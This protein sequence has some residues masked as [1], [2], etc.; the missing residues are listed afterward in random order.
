MDYGLSKERIVMKAKLRELLPEKTLQIQNALDSEV[1]SLY[2]MDKMWNKGFGDWE[3]ECKYRSGEK[4][5]CT[6]YAPKDVVAIGKILLITGDMAA[7]NSVF[8][9]QRR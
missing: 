4:T 6:F 5:L 1:D 2:D 9:V 7:G 8:A 3:I